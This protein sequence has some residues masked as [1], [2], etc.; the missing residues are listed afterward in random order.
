[1]QVAP[2]PIPAVVLALGLG[3]DRS[4]RAKEKAQEAVRSISADN[5]G[6]IASF[7]VMT[8]SFWWCKTFGVAETH[9][10]HLKHG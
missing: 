1:M 3:S 9:T 7:T 6:L 10:T 5:D 4:D 8:S 2:V